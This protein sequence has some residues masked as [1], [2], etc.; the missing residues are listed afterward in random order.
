[1]IAMIKFRQFGNFRRTEKILKRLG[2]G[3]YLK[4][5]EKF[6]EAGV[7]ALQ[8]ATPVDTGKTASSWSYSIE[9]TK[10][11]VS[12]SWNNSNI[13]KGLNIAVLI[14]YGHATGDGTYIEGV[15]YINPSLRPIFALIAKKAWEEVTRNAE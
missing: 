4:G 10:N 1:M 5:L 3:D 2:D 7:E 11:G 13:N 9:K 8:A 6:G 15:D 12:I 14:Q